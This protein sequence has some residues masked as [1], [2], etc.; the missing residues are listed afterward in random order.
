MIVRET[1][2]F[3]AKAR[4]HRLPPKDVTQNRY[5]VHL[6][7]DTMATYGIQHT[8]NTKVRSDPVRRNSGGERH[9]ITIAEI[10]VSG[11]SFAVLG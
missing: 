4:A 9:R 5:A 8:F 6:R 2:L 7:D 3:A 10:A 1:L 11:A